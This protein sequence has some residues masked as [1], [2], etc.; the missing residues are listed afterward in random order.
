ML[1]RSFANLNTFNL[2]DYNC[3]KMA[4]TSYTC[5]VCYKP[6]SLCVGQHGKSYK[7][8]TKR[9]PVPQHKIDDTLFDIN[10]ADDDEFKKQRTIDDTHDMSTETTNIPDGIKNLVWNKYIGEDTMKS[11]CFCCKMTSIYDTMFHCGFVKSLQKGGS[12]TLTNLLP[13]CIHC[14]SCTGNM[15]I[16]DF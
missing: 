14:N 9:S 11:L 7:R 2:V 13:I 10:V 16:A 15:S 1:C 12:I 4:S 3:D 6:M 5:G 8:N